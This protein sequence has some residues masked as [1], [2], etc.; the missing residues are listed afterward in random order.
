LKPPAGCTFHPRCAFAVDRCRNERPELRP[1]DGG[2]E[3]AC[4]R[5]GEIPQP[6]A[7]EPLPVPG[8]LTRRLAILEAARIKEV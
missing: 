2:G 4:H 6:V 7:S 5:L 3:A 8:A 1:L